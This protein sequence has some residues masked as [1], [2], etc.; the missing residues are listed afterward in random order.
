MKK[1]IFL[2][3]DG[4]INE[5]PGRFTEH[6]YVTNTRDFRFLPGSLAAIKDLSEAGYDIFI[7]S[8]QGGISKG[9]F[10]ESDLREITDKMTGEIEKA[11]GRIK[12]VYYCTH[13]AS[14]N[15]DC[16]K[17]GTGLLDAAA[18]EFGHDIRGAFFIGDG[19]M[20]IE[21]GHKKGL[22]TAL[23]LSGKTDIKDVKSWKVKPDYIFK[24]LREAVCFIVKRSS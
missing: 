16:K 11:G 7:I 8:N 24:D 19:V 3:R 10:K 18:R 1:I 2:D 5:D 6:G 9:L 21:A 13:Q 14:D 20:D 23:L 15:C 12:K 22:K 4:V 17:P